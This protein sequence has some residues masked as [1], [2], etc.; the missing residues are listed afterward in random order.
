MPL[1]GEAGG[2]P[3]KPYWVRGKPYGCPVKFFEQRDKGSISLNFF[4]YT[5]VLYLVELSRYSL[6]RFEMRYHYSK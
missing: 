6:K 5:C 1:L 2:E 4:F 3:R